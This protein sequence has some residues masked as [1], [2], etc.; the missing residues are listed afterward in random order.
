ML[1]I[2]GV[3]AEGTVQAGEGKEEELGAGAVDVLAFVA[4]I[5]G[6]GAAGGGVGGAGVDLVDGVGLTG[7]IEVWAGINSAVASPP[8]TVYQLNQNSGTV[9]G[10]PVSSR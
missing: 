8:V 2:E 6:I 5:F 10:S 7:I 3:G 4:L 1:D 9:S